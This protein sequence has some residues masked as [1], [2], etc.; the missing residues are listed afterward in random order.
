M[1]LKKITKNKIFTGWRL[2][3]VAE[4][5]KYALVPDFLP[6]CILQ[7][8]FRYLAEAPAPGEVQQPASCRQCCAAP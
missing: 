3:R 6:V 7:C 1:N 2:G 4:L 5:S 8:R